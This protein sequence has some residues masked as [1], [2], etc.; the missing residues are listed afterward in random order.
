[1][2][3]VEVKLRIRERRVVSFTLRLLYFRAKRTLYPSERRLREPQTV[4][5]WKRR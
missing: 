3:R 1:M 2:G 4:Q 5:T